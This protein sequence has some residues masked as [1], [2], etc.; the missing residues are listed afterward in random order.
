[1]SIA[2]PG[3]QTSAAPAEFDV[4]EQERW[5]SIGAGGLLLGLAVLRGGPVSTLA[6][7]TGAALLARGVTRRDPVSRLLR[8]NAHERE[9]ARAR[10]WSAAAS[11]TATVTI[12]RPRHELYAFWRDFTNLP[13]FLPAVKRIDVIDGQRSRWTV[14]A[15]GG[16]TVSWEAVLVRDELDRRIGWESEDGGDIRNAGSVSFR[17]VAGGRATEVSAEILYEPPAGPL[18][19]AVVAMFR[20]KPSL[21]VRE[22]LERLKALMEAD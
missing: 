3:S 9:E 4:S 5:L 7:L 11:T 13:R 22:G 10:G 8:P 19:R 14:A 6:A 17:D 20:E 2:T 18:G 21:Q 16:A 15:P 12:A 1:M